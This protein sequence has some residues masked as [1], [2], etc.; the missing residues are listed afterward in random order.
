MTCL[1]RAPSGNPESLADYIQRHE[2]ALIELTAAYPDQYRR[3][4][5]RFGL[6]A[7]DTRGDSACFIFPWAY[8]IPADCRYLYYADDGVLEISGYSFFETACIDGL[9]INGQGYIC[10]TMLRPNWFFVES[11]IPT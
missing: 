1:S 5:G 9:G 11:Y 7:I 4:S 10:C 2:A 3:L 8:D 6:E